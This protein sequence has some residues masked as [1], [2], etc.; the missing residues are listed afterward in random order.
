MRGDRVFDHKAIVCVEPRGSAS[1]DVYTSSG[2]RLVTVMSFYFLLSFFL[3]AMSYI[4]CYLRTLYQ[5]Q[6]SRDKA[7][8]L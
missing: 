1:E 3:K 8:L 7:T 6:I 4:I 5:Q 2:G